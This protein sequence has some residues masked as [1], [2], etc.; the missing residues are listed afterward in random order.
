MKLVG[1][2]RSLMLNVIFHPRITRAKR[3]L[4]EKR[5]QLTGRRHVV[6]VFLQIDDPYSYILSH[7]LPQLAE[8]FDIDLRLFLSEARGDEY[9]PAPELLAEYAVTDCGRLANELGIHF[10]DKGSSPPTEHRIGLSDAVASLVGSEAFDSELLQALATYWRGD[11]AAA[12]D[13]RATPEA[14]GKARDVISNAQ[15]LR[16]SLGHYNSAM[17][18]YGGEWYWGVDRL[19]YLMDR[20]IELGAIRSATPDPTLASIQ[21]AMQYSLPVKPPI[22][23][24]KLPPVEIFH[25]PRSPYSYLALKRIYDI[26][27]AFGLQ[28][29]MRP[30]LP[31]V[32]RGMKVP[33]PKLLYIAMDTL[34]EARRLG[35]AYGKPADPIGPG[36]ERFMAVYQYAESEHRARDFVLNAGAAIWAEATD[37]ATDEGMRKVTGRT[38][39]FW[40]DVKKAMQSDDWRSDIDANR[41]SMMDSGSWGVPTVKMGE[42]VFWGQDRDWML[43]RHIE[44][45]CDTGDGILV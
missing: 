32:M 45:L 9:Q 28:L 23:A 18:H 7:F 42:F 25:S 15:K 21:Q 38:G 34:R 10:L 39:L 16:N 40:P 30:V 13:M 37:I 29:V 20:L 3:W 22:A 44:E 6:S 2:F 33:Q 8:R 26:V 11:S 41:E 14:H 31:M 1:K 36:V 4:T 17:L 27:D 43:V 5:R 35:E 12:A 24:K 19:H